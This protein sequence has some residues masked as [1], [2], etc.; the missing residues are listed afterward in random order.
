MMHCI[1]I[2]ASYIDVEV[3]DH[4]F[5]LPPDSSESFIK[6]RIKELLKYVPK[7]YKF[8]DYQTVYRYKLDVC[9]SEFLDL[10]P[11]CTVDHLRVIFNTLTSYYTFVELKSIFLTESN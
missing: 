7:S 6:A 3:H 2:S 8:W 10:C 5:I 9:N 1:E 4:L 11:D